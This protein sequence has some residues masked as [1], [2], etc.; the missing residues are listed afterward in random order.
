MHN[1]TDI[2]LG[3]YCLFYIIYILHSMR[4]TP[5][6]A[7]EIDIVCLY[8]RFATAC[9]I[10]F[11]MPDKFD[12]FISQSNNILAETKSRMLSSVWFCESYSEVPKLGNY[13]IAAPMNQ[14]LDS[15]ILYLMMLILSTWYRWSSAVVRSSTHKS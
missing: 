11:V 15:F 9:C 7:K 2:T 12:R 1:Y 8:L 14:T 4:P 6:L 5:H 3:V 13:F 10:A